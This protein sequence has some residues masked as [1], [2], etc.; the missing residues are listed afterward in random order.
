MFEV[1]EGSGEVKDLFEADLSRGIG[2]GEDVMDRAQQGRVHRERSTVG[3][4]DQ[5]TSRK[6]IGVAAD[7]VVDGEKNFGSLDGVHPVRAGI[8]KEFDDAG[9]MGAVGL[10]ASKMTEDRRVF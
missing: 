6:P 9:G 8:G 10:V 3:L 4:L 7:E 2:L 5:V 1:L